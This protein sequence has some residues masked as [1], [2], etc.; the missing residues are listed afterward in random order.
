VQTAMNGTA[1]VFQ[2]WPHQR[3]DF[4]E[5][6]TANDEEEK[7][8]PS[9]AHNDR[10]SMQAPEKKPMLERPMTGKTGAVI[11][12]GTS[13]RGGRRRTQKE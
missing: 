9:L 3:T 13:G 12:L 1:G 5:E 8:E 11:T 10:K 2:G 4:P 7:G 6:S